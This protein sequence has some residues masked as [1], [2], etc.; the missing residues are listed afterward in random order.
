L[1]GGMK[2]GMVPSSGK[3]ASSIRISGIMVVVD[4]PGVVLDDTVEVELG[5]VLR[6]LLRVLA[7]EV[8]VGLGVTLELEPLVDKVIVDIVMLEAEVEGLVE[9]VLGTD[10]IA[11]TDVEMLAAP[12]VPVGLVDR[13]S[14]VLSSVVTDVP[15][16]M[17]AVAP[18]DIVELT[19][20]VLGVDVELDVKPLE[21]PVIP[22]NVLPALMPSVLV[23]MAE[24]VSLGV[25]VE[26]VCGVLSTV[27]EVPPVVSTVVLAGIDVEMLA[28]LVEAV[29][30]V[31][32]DADILTPVVTDSLVGSDKVVLLVI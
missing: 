29:V 2:V 3:S 20:E 21:V 14:V 13:G 17:V 4:E 7:S 12:V 23:G 19:G 31:G 6:V 26:L 22:V 8:V 32:T 27:T 28:P 24:V 16:G 5:P 9:T 15:V 10:V 25:S 1:K 18:L 30:A 11:G